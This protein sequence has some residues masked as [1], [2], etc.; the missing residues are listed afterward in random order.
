MKSKLTLFLSAILFSVGVQAQSGLDNLDFED[1]G[2]NDLGEDEPIGF[3]SLGATQN[4]GDPKEGSSAVHLEV[5]YNMVIDDTLAAVALGEIAGQS[6]IDIG[7]LY[8]NCPDSLTGYV[9][10]ELLNEDTATIRADVW[11]N[12]NDTLASAELLLGG[13]EGSWTRISIPFDPM[14]CNGNT[15]DS[16]GIYMTAESVGFDTYVDEFEDKGTQTIG[17]VLELD[18]FYLHDSSTTNVVSL[19]EKEEKHEVYPNPAKDEVRFEF[20]SGAERIRIFDMTGRE[21]KEVLL[22]GVDEEASVDLEGMNE[23]LYVY[24]IEGSQGQELHSGKLQVL[25]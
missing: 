10:H 25:R 5:Y 8:S 11:T 4:T 2:S 6:S 7:E 14:D 21:A 19:S 23:G 9:R 13:T 16:V 1:W 12:A 17:S 22:N 20:G 18:A 3:A 24:R 15:P